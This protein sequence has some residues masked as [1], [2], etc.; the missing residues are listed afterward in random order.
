M[1]TMLVVA[2]LLPAVALADS[3]QERVAAARRYQEVADMRTTVDMA[4]VEVAN[5]MGRQERDAYLEHMRK[6][7]R[8]DVLEKAALDSMVKVFTSEEMNALADFY[9]TP[10]GKSALAKFGPYV[11]DL[12]PAIQDEFVRAMQLM[13]DP[14]NR[15]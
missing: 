6:T 1:R 11:A 14:R 12:M 2:M 9:K 7:V 5:T 10:V 15:R 3:D 13:P 8:M 4:L